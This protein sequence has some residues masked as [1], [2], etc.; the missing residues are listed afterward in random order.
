MRSKI[1]INIKILICVFFL[2][3]HLQADELQINSSQI[4]IDKKTKTT[5][6]EGNVKAVDEKNNQIFTN[7][8]SY[9]KELKLFKST[10]ATKIITSEGYTINGNDMSFN[11]INKT[12]TSDKQTNVIDKDGNQIFMNMFNYLTNKNLF[13]SKGEINIIDKN[14][15]EYN[16]SE[17]YIDEKQNKIVGTE[18]KVFLKD[19]SLKSNPDNEPRFFANNLVMQNNSSIFEKGVFTYCKDKGS[20]KKPAWCLQSNKI[21]HNASTK[22]IY[23]DK[24][25]IKVYDFPIFYFP[26]L[27]HPDPTVDRRSGFLAPTTTSSKN[28]GPGVEIPYY[29][30]MSKDKDFLFSPKLYAQNNHLFLGEYRQDFKNSFLIVDGGFTQGYK[31]TSDKK[32]KGSRSHLFSKFNMDFFSLNEKSSQLEI[33]VQQVSNDTHVKVHDINSTLVNNDISEL[34]NTIDYEYNDRD[35]FLGVNVSAFKNLSTT[36]NARYEYLLPDITLEKNLLTTDNLGVLDLS[37]RFQV[38]NYEVDKQIELFV[39]DFLWDS[40]K[41]VSN[42][43]LENQLKGIIKTSSYNATNTDEFKNEDT[44]S[45]FAGALGILSKLDFYK[46]NFDKSRRHFLTPK[47]FLRHA[48]G[49]MRSDALGS[50]RL[51]V[52]NLYEINKSSEIDILEKGTSASLGF[53]FSINNLDKDG[54]IGEEKLKISAG[55]VINLEEDKD[56]SVKSSMD[57]RFSDIVGSA[58][59]KASDNMTLKYQFAVDQ[60]IKQINYNE[61][62]LE[63]EE[64]K[65][66]F[67]INYLQER[68]HIGNEEYIESSIDLNLTS[69]SELSFSNKRNLVT[70]SSEFYSLSYNY[71]NDCLKAGLV[72]RREFYTDRDIEPENSLMFKITLTP[73]GG[74][75]APALGK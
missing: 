42:F 36:G 59:Y 24:A 20:N 19:S 14:K 75:S 47:V 55:Q 22:T 61:I 30:A 18:V 38:R 68:E 56:M 21:E 4:K 43:G 13:F 53:D 16:F 48:P 51:T 7:F 25:V 9:D 57:Q 66:Q 6:F 44:S 29:W 31:K 70:E 32:T 62:G 12:I 60:N 65:V 72:Y 35:L 69:S 1:Y 45:M 39:N 3:L 34:K 23:Y 33:N 73:L 37:S 40:N 71:L 17:I 8:A 63:L 28:I 49:H 67:N 2:N 50:E 15:N 11:N 74:L 10:G 46:D 5:I 52:S 27:S 26:K 54:L 64:G 41:W 58:M